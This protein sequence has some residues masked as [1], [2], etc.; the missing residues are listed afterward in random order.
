VGKHS[1]LEV[2]GFDVNCNVN[3]TSNFVYVTVT[4]HSLSADGLDQ[5]IDVN[6]Y[7]KTCTFTAQGLF[8][9]IP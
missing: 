3:T 7:V 1:L 9:S 8:N 5:I 2:S 6:V 4:D